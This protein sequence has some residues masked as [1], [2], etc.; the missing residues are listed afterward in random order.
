ML[1]EFRDFITRG[2]VVDLAV[3]FVLGAAFTVIVKSMV[4]DIL[5]PP[6]GLLFGDSSLADQFVTL[7]DGAT[8][9]PYDTLIAAK[10][11]G[12]VTLNYGNFIDA[13]VAFLIVGFAMFMIVKGVRKMEESRAKEEA[14]APPTTKDCPHCQSTISIT[15]NRCAFCTSELEASP[16]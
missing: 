11:A 1:K 12:A 16:A 10:E 5:M 14:A 3:A 2:N 15:A 4:S 13:I 7:K 9:G 6:V 8:A